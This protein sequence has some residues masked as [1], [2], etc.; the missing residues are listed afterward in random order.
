MGFNE[1]QELTPRFKLIL[2]DLP[3]VLPPRAPRTELI[4]QIGQLRE[5]LAQACQQIAADHAQKTLMDQENGQLR[6]Q[7]FQK[8]KE[9]DNSRA[10]TSSARLLTHQD[11]LILFQVCRYAARMKDVHEELPKAVSARVKR[12][13]AQEKEKQ[14]TANEARQA[15]ERQR[16]ETERLRKEAERQLEK[17]RKTAEREAM[18]R[19][20]ELEREAEK[21]RKAADRTRK[22]GEKRKEMEQRAIAK[23]PRTKRSK[24]TRSEAAV[25][26]DLSTATRQVEK[27]NTHPMPRVPLLLPSPS[28]SLSRSPALITLD[29]D[30]SPILQDQEGAHSIVNGHESPGR[31]AFSLRNVDPEL[32]R[33]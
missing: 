14:R 4:T 8:T 1:D 6:T 20:K 25:S 18:R 31:V 21:S 27:E 15:D 19:A 5:L 33:P 24:T 30:K 11:T 26:T 29:K 3:N 23:G 12:L 17:Q 7:L 9:K 22:A 13:E 32:L 16:R 28:H 10:L 2:P